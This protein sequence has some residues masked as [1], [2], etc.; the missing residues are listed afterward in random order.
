MDI[1]GFI[2]KINP[3]SGA[4]SIGDITSQ[5]FDEGSY[6]TPFK[7]F[8]GNFLKNRAKSFPLFAVHRYMVLPDGTDV[9]GKPGRLV[10]A[11]A[12]CRV[13]LLPDKSNKYGQ[14]VVKT[15]FLL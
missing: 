1:N 15:C 9:K 4:I 10:E 12:N 13:A 8:R 7:T 3:V 2:I 11:C 6:G 14:R 5:C